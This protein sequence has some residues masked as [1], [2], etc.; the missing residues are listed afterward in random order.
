VASWH[1]LA[2]VDRAW[3]RGKAI[4]ET[5]GAAG[6]GARLRRHADSVFITLGNQSGSGSVLNDGGRPL[7]EKDDR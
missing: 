6:T 7:Q 5:A 3:C 1:K 2:P 4:S